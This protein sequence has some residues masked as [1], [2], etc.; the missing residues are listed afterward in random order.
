MVIHGAAFRR[1]DVQA[2]I[3]SFRRP[4][5]AQEPR[6]APKKRRRAARKF[7]WTDMYMGLAA[8][9]YVHGLD[10]AFEKVFDQ[11]GWQTDLEGWISEYFDGR[12]LN[13]GDGTPRIEAQRFME[14]VRE[15]KMRAR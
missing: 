7:D 2:M 6:N 5:T 15:E 13:I 11:E 8:V 1:S 10:Q 9:A 3:D 4:P 14:A 12:G